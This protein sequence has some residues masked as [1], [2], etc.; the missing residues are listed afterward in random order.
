VFDYL[1]EHDVEFKG[2]YKL[3]NISSIKIGGPAD[4]VAFPK[5][6]SSLISLISFLVNEKIHYKI[7]GRMTNILPSDKGFRGVVISTKHLDCLD[8]RDSVATADAGV[9]LPYMIKRL[10]KIGLGGMESLSGIPGSIGGA[11]ANNAGAFGS[12]ISTFFLNARLFSVKEKK[13]KVLD[14]RDMNFGYRTSILSKKDNEFILLNATFAFSKREIPLIENDISKITQRRK[15]TQ[16][17]ELPTLGS[18]F[19]KSG[20][21]SISK[22]VDEIGLKGFSTGGAYI[23]E[24]HAGFIVNK[25]NASANDVRRLISIIKERVYRAYGIIPR[26]EI[27]FL[28]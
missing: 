25:G 14:C 2:N 21:V 26:E 4:V 13:V 20:D 6:E 10:A 12:E 24:K 9:G 11:V 18:V 3:S 1:K 19:K 22:L 28:E 27:E 17:I 16:P 8:V 23:S 15:A 5:N 7:V